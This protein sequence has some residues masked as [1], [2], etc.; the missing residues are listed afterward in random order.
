MTADEIRGLGLL[1]VRDAIA[2]GALTSVEVTE[3]A[4][5]QAERFDASHHLFITRMDEAALDAAAAAD[6]M[7]AAG[8]PLGPLHGVPVTIKDNIDVAGVPATAGTLVWKD[9]VPAVDA[10]AV[11]RLRRAGAIVLG[12]VNMH[13]MAMGGTSINPHYGPVRNPWDPDMIPG[14]SSGASAACVSLQI[15]YASLGTDAAGSVRIPA[16]LCGQVGLKQTHGLVPQLGLMPTGTQHVDH[17]GPHAR[18]VADVRALLQVLAGPDADDPSSSPRVA[19]PAPPRTDLAGLTVGLPHDWFWVD[20]HPEVEEMARATVGLMEAAGA[21]VV[22]VDLVL[23]DLLPLIRAA[24]SAEAYV[25]HQPMLDATPELYGPDL[26]FRLLAGQYVLAQDYVRALRVRR[27]VIE[28]VRVTMATVD[29]LA[30]PTLPVPAFR[31]DA[32]PD[33]AATLRLIRNTS[34]FNQT[35]HPAISLPMGCTS[36]GLPV[37]FQLVADVFEDH[38]LLAAAEVLEGLIGFDATPPVLRDALVAP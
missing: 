26:R 12:K 9:R 8:D 23:S 24:M 27:L 16:D 3:A 30:M 19:A 36:A 17:I 32:E 28:R 31:V 1:A 34:P 25:Y 14:G 10:V 20:L 6:A 15:G 35:G 22:P 18:S 29:L 21:S 38:R 11:A 33:P 13:E 2:D 37:G 5:A 7:R 4:I